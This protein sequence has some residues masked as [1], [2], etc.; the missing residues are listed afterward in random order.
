LAQRVP[1]RLTAAEGRKF[2]VTVGIAFLVLA[3]VVWW[4]EHPVLATAFGS[5]GGLLTLAG[6]AVP[7]LLGPVQRGWMG[8]AHAISRVT[9]PIVMGVVYFV[10]LAPIGVLMRVF[11]RNPLVRPP[12]GDTFWIDRA[13]EG[14][15]GTMDNQF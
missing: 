12:S 2:G 7:T 6:L 13:G 14:G 15:R 1:A 3:A 11:G 4:R 5:L 10:V 9:T 8:L